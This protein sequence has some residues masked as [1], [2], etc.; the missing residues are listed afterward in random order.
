[1]G[2]HAAGQAVLELTVFVRLGRPVRNRRS[3]ARHLPAASPG[4]NYATG[5]TKVPAVR[6][7]WICTGDDELKKASR[8][9]PDTVAALNSA[10]GPG[11]PVPV[12]VRSRVIDHE[13]VEAFLARLPTLLAARVVTRPHVWCL[14][15]SW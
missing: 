2:W 4:H 3:L 5:G 9:E 15:S 6:P 10:T 13:Q 1:M 12:T 7:A 8:A 14:V 11:R